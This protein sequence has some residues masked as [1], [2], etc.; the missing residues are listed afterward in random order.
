MASLD[1]ATYA[2]KSQQPLDPFPT[3]SEKG[4][5][6]FTPFRELCFLFE[7]EKR[8]FFIYRDIPQIS[9]L[10][11]TP[12]NGIPVYRRLAA[13]KNEDPI[14]SFYVGTAVLMFN[15]MT[16]SYNFLGCRVSSKVNY[17]NSV[18]SFTTFLNASDID[19]PDL[20]W[21]DLKALGCRCFLEL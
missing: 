10:L 3:L 5:L 9:K 13:L 6:H 7:I 8:I 20:E 1:V 4:I 12:S 21:E 11:L 2:D 14:F 16:D 17:T 18:T 15:D 19:G